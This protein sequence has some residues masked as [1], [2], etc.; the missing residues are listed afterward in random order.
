MN[1]NTIWLYWEDRPGIPTPP[2]ILL[3]RE[4]LKYQ[5]RSCEIRLV[6]PQNLHFYLPDIDD[7][8][9]EIS[10][11]N[12]QQ[13]PIAVRCAFIRAFLLERYGGLYV[14]SDCIALR[15]YTDIFSYL[16]NFD[17]IGI[18]RTSAKTK[19]ISIGFYASK[20]SGTVISEYAEQLRKIL[21]EKT[22]FSWGEVGAHLL[23]P[24][25]NSHLDKVLLFRENQIHP[26]VAEQQHEFCNNSLNLKDVISPDAYCFMLFHRIFEQ[27]VSGKTLRSASVWD[28]YFSDKLIS[29]VFRLVYPQNEFT[30]TFG[31]SSNG[32]ET[33]FNSFNFS[34]QKL[35]SIAQKIQS[36]SKKLSR[37]KNE[38]QKMY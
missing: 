5:C 13:N 23:T 18:R 36:S 11:R 17:F 33:L 37:L 8:I 25:V 3:C 7:R 31:Y 20:Q 15:D 22:V 16:H 26:I 9:W 10:L 35:L 14:D 30:K 19:H 28:L 24:I 29:R 2:H 34:H 32:Q 27:Q 1:N 12:K 6:T 21:K 38:I 4:V